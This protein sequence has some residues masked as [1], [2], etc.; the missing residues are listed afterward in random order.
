[1]GRTEKAREILVI[2]YREVMHLLLVP[3][4]FVGGEAGQPFL[5]PG[6]YKTRTP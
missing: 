6:L 2:D 4:C 1:M 5:F 3:I